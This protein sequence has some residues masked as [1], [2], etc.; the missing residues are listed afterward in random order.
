MTYD[1]VYIAITVYHELGKLWKRKEKNEKNKNVC[2]VGT[3][4]SIIG[5]K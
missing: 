2:K 4:V 5:C 3:S 1:M